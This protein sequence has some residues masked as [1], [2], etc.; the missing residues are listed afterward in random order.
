MLLLSS[1]LDVCFIR[2]LVMVCN[3][4]VLVEKEL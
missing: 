1:C 2:I 4:I 3:I